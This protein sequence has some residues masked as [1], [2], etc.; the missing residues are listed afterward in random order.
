M[1]SD[2][3]SRPADTA[4]GSDDGAT[5]VAL[6]APLLLGFATLA[7]EFAL[8]RVAAPW[9]GQGM[10]VWANTVATVLFALAL[11]YAAGGR[12]ADRGVGG[13][14]V[15]V[16]LALAAAWLCA[17][18]VFAPDL[19][20]W[21]TP[22]SIGADRPHPIAIG[23]SLAATTILAGPPLLAI[24]A[25]TPIWVAWARRRASAGR[26][27]GRVSAL[28]TLGGLAGCA[29]VPVVLVPTLGSR[30][31]LL[32]AAGT[33]GA[34]ALAASF[35]RVVARAASTTAAETDRE[36]PVTPGATWTTWAAGLAAFACGLVL[37]MVE[38]AV[39]RRLAPALGTT[40]GTWALVIGGLLVACAVGAAVGT[41]RFARRWGWT[42]PLFIAMGAVGAVTRPA[43]SGLLRLAPAS[44]LAIAYG[45]LQ[46]A[47][48]P[49]ALVD[50]LARRGRTGRSVALVFA[51]STAGNVAGCYLAPLWLLPVLGTRATFL[52]AAAAAALGVVAARLVRRARSVATPLPR[53]ERPTAA[54]ASSS[55]DHRPV[56]MARGLAFASIATAVLATRWIRGPL[57]VD[58]GQLEEVETAYATIRA[59]ERAEFAAKPGAAPLYFETVKVP[60]RFLGFDE[61][62]TSYQSIRLVDDEARL[63]T[64]GRYYDQLALGAWFAGQPWTRPDGG[65]MRV[66]IVGYCGGTLHR[67][68]AALA[69]AGRAPVVT[70]IEIDP[71]VV[72]LATRRL[73]PLPDGVE[74]LT[75]VDGRAAMAGLPSERVFD[76]ILVDAYQRT[77]YVPFHLSSRE[78][79]EECRRRLSPNGL[80]GINS[81]SEMGAGGR[82]VE[83]LAETMSAAFSGSCWLVPNPLFPGNVAIWGS[84]FPAA[85]R[86]ARGVDPRLSG[87]AFTLDRFLVR[88]VPGSG[89]G[90]VMTDDR[91]PT[92]ALADDDLLALEDRR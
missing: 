59:V 39:V 81:D 65:P 7:I 72:R 18:A 82:L 92:E 6:L 52:V 21:L 66:L 71:D 22:A 48:V 42:A 20:R 46:T 73:G 16:V 64:G 17:A 38:F 86:V 91:A 10:H 23:S 63:L 68:L 31:V 26:A 37:T 5:I 55:T 43:S 41:T 13:A 53:A 45:V 85:P 75:G 8:V 11:G 2:A 44:V 79:F 83:C 3:A 35:V 54:S 12:A 4:S 90:F 76:L 58:E 24:G 62:T 80:L 87:A 57:R 32:L 29:L 74:L 84:S 36:D 28:G 33:V 56:W 15:G 77:Q 47:A 9:F 34:C 78:F 50:D 89:R 14:G 30:G 51:A 60:T 40:N 1:T 49:P 61:D 27:S 88:F 67:V 70:G 69:P 19:A 25:V